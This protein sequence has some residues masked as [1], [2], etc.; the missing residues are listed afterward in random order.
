MSEVW[1]CLNEKHDT[2]CPQP[3]VAC[4]AEGCFDEE[5]EDE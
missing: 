5:E 1:F 3:C 2:P 4:E